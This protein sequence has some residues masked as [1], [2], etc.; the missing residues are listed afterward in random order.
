MLRMLDYAVH[1]GMYSGLTFDAITTMYRPVVNCHDEEG[2]VA[3]AGLTFYDDVHADY[4]EE[5]PRAN[6]GALDDMR[7]AG[8][9][10][11]AP[12]LWI[13]LPLTPIGTDVTSCTKASSTLVPGC[14]A[15]LSLRVTPGQ[16]AEGASR[17]LMAHLSENAP[18]GAQFEMEL[19]ESD[20][21]F[22]AGGNTPATVA[23][24]QVLR[25]A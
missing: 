7:L 2:V 9:G 20:P 21:A 13:Q 22:K 25:E 15:R 11:L 24:Q 23:T 5:N 4:L 14:K 19:E 17:A 8:R 18:F 10:S 6:I 1:S 16:D 12:R 3:V